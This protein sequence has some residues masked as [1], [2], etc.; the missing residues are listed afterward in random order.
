MAHRSRVAV[1]AYTFPQ[2]PFFGQQRKLSGM[3]DMGMCEKYKVY[4]RG[5]HGK[6]AVFINIWALL[7]AA[8]YQD[9]FAAGFKQGAG[10]SNL[11]CCTEKRQ[12]H[13]ILRSRFSFVGLSNYIESP[14]SYID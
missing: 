2:K 12:F 6:L 4:G 9:F 7:H 11:V 8:V 10:A 3:I 5:R 1:V 13:K 14:W